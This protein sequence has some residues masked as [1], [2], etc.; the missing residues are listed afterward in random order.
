MI[1]YAGR[2]CEQKRP[3]LFADILREIARRGISYRALVVGDGELRPL[4]GRLIRKYSLESSVQML[5]TV[6]HQRWL[7]ILS[8]ADIFLLPSKYEG[9]SVALFEAMAMKV[10]P[11]VAAVGGH[12]EVVNSDCGFLVPQCPDEMNGYADAVSF[13]IRDP[14]RRAAMARAS[15]ERIRRDF[16]RAQTVSRLVSVL[17]HAGSLG[18]TNP[19]QPVSPGLAQELATFAVE[20]AR[21]NGVADFLWGHWT[22]TTSNLAASHSM[23][24]GN[25]GRLLAILANTRIGSTIGR[26]RTIRMVGKWLL[27]R[28]EARH[29]FQPHTGHK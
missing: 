15:H 19:R 23:P 17:D 4:L 6:D 13:L 28:L 9:I 8:A 2:I 12:S 1:V 27:R 24:I 10:V 5:G 18:R 14:E 20:Y 29:Q 26:N 25:L 3:Q 22:Q 11:V 21:L 7:E 16:T